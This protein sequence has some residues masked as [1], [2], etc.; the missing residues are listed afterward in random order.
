MGLLHLNLKRDRKD[1]LSKN[2]DEESDETGLILI[3]QE[4]SI[5]NVDVI[6]R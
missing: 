3:Q 2:T 5:A 1:L 4:Q 6:L